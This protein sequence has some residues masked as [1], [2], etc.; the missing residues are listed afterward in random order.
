[1][2]SSALMVPL[3]SLSKT[4]NAIAASFRGTLV[5]SFGKISLAVDMP[6]QL[7]TMVFNETNIKSG[8]FQISGGRESDLITGVDVSYIEP[9]NHY[10][11]EVARIDT[12]DANETDKVPAFYIAPQPENR[13]AGRGVADGPDAIN[14]AMTLARHNAMMRLCRNLESTTEGRVTTKSTQTARGASSGTASQSTVFSQ[15]Q[16]RAEVGNIEPIEM[17]VLQRNEC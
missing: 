5:H 1:M 7:P 3:P 14:I 16:C 17:K 4:L 11:R 15:S 12:I 8:S 6:D 13:A 10:K 9:T 2:S